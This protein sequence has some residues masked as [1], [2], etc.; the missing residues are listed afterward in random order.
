[1]PGGSGVR[2]VRR[3]GVGWEAVAGPRIG[4]R[5]TA[6]SGRGRRLVDRSGVLP[7]AAV[8]V[9]AG[10]VAAGGGGRDPP[11]CRVEACRMREGGAR[12][13][14]PC[15]VRAGGCEPTVGG[16][17]VLRDSRRDAG[18]LTRKILVREAARRR[19]W[20]RRASDGRRPAARWHNR[21]SG[22][23]SRTAVL[24]SAAV[25]RVVGG[26]AGRRCG[27]IDH[28]VR[29]GRL[30]GWRVS[31]GAGRCA[32]GRGRSGERGAGR[33]RAH[34]WLRGVSAQRDD[35]LLRSAVP[36][37]DG[38]GRRGRWAPGPGCGRVVAAGGRPAV[39]GREPAG[40]HA[41]VRA[42]FRADRAAAAM[43]AGVRAGGRGRN[44]SSRRGHRGAARRARH[45]G[46]SRALGQSCAMTR[47]RM[48][49]S[50]I[51]IR[52]LRRDRGP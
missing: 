14:T 19:G 6:G 51:K 23:R 25:R 39:D 43:T 35:V 49:R 10:G 41:H 26:P 2:A 42:G 1:V 48:F 47:N 5:A 11:A 8:V 36:A 52:P 40:R 38:A 21:A 29:T 17:V 13:P 34:G 7:R 50:P 20:R 31:G 37:G 45:P 4:L 3:V 30:G 15:P 27:R 12:S 33:R 24:T 46:M 18:R 32:S 44:R 9:I 22:R 16:V 28:G